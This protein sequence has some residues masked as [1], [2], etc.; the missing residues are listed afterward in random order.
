[1][2]RSLGKMKYLSF[3]KIRRDRGPRRRNLERT[4]KP[5]NCLNSGPRRK[6]E[7]NLKPQSSISNGLTLPFNLM[8]DKYSN[9]LR[10]H[11]L[12]FENIPR[13]FR[14]KQETLSRRYV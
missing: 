13:L 2:L 9:L 4:R 6:H 1:M 12:E 7:R 5:S 8:S 3:P 14:A 10:L 11:R